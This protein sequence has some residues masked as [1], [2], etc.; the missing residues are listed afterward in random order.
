MAV[1]HCRF[2]LKCAQFMYESDMQ[3]GSTPVCSKCKTPVKH[4]PQKRLDTIREELAV[5]NTVERE[6]PSR[7]PMYHTDSSNP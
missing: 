2:H 6:A 5:S 4:S 7:Q 1:C 3:S